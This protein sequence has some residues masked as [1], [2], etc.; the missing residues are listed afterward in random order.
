MSSLRG[1]MTAGM[2][3]VLL[4]AVL[5]VGA[6]S[7]IA[8]RHFLISR[9]DEQLISAGGHYAA[10]LE[11]PDRNKPHENAGDHDPDD[12]IPGASQGTL[13]LRLL[14]GRITE[15][16]VVG[17]DG[18]T[19]P[20][21]LDRA[22]ATAVR[23]IR[24]GSGAHTLD[25]H[26]LGD[27]RTRAVL[28]RDGDVQLTGLPLHPVNETL[29]QL[30]IVE[31]SLFAGLV[32]LGGAAAALFV[33]R[34]L[35]PLDRLAHTALE[36]ST[37]ALTGGDEPLPTTATPTRPTREVD[38]VS[39]AFD[40]MLD[41][42]RNAMSARDA[43]EERL[44]QFV[45]DASHELRTPLATIRASAEYGATPPEGP[46]PGQT[47]ESLA[48][49]TA[50]ADRMGVLVADLLLLARLDAGRPLLHDVVDLTRVVLDA[51]ADARAAAP[52]HHWELD[53]PEE[54]V[55][56]DGDE[57]RLHRALANLLANAR[58][59]T[60]PGTTVTTGV[61]L[62]TD[63]VEAWVIDTGPGVPAQ[64]RGELFE[65][66]TRGDT[67]RS[68]AH[69]STGLGLAIAH[70]IVRAHNGTLGYQTAPTG[71]ACFRLVLPTA[72]RRATHE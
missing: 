46:L 17:E 70:G 25:L 58:A 44:R 69:G 65:R 22:S 28:G 40:Q 37:L 45:A 9:L 24:P 48:R 33:R 29:L 61:S 56:V 1:R 55:T 60:P 6:V 64:M 67:S 35:R 36:V 14:D 50:A 32:L 7:E 26:A 63:H 20:V 71:G 30:L 53:L 21:T 72:P 8:L 51:V 15:A 49:I 16:A 12:V 2:I 47:A 66:F 62:A 13:G 18:T 42:V 59:H 57:E 10:S 11:H 34:S 43:T 27:Y 31:A 19:D 39:H 38:Q 54:A 41:R 23:R 5:L 68:R 4:V 3:A 52:D